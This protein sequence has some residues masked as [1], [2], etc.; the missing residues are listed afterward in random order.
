MTATICCHTGSAQPLNCSDPTGTRTPNRL[1]RRQMLCPVGRWA[2]SRISFHRTKCPK[3]TIPVLCLCFAPLIGPNSATNP[4]T[5]WPWTSQKMCPKT[6]NKKTWQS[7]LFVFSGEIPPVSNRGN[8]SRVAAPASCS[9]QLKR[10]SKAVSFHLRS[11]EQWPRPNG[12]HDVLLQCPN[13][14]CHFRCPN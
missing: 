9:P 6:I 7:L 8:H 14:N 1:L 10:P 4:N 5:E 3:A 11:N 2:L 12:K 13:S